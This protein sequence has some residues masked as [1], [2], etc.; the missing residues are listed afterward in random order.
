MLALYYQRIA[1]WLITKKEGLR[2]EEGDYQHANKYR[3]LRD[4][5]DALPD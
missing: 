2:Y 4:T 1:N 5:N 3:L